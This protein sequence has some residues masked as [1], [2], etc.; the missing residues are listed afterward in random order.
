MAKRLILQVELAQVEDIGVCS[1]IKRV[2]FL[3][4]FLPCHVSLCLFF[5]C[6]ILCRPLWCYFQSDE[7]RF[8]PVPSLQN[9]STPFVIW[10]LCISFLPVKS[11]PGRSKPFPLPGILISVKIFIAPKGTSERH[12][13]HP[14]S[15]S[16]SALHHL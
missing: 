7:R 15:P 16:V 14:R 9:L 4:P 3:V 6:L 1:T 12:H 8:L 5:Q 13:K 10:F 11:F 2:P